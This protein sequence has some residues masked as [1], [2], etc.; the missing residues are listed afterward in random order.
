[1]QLQVTVRRIICKP[2]I[3][4]RVNISPYTAQGSSSPHILT[5]GMHFNHSLQTT[6]RYL[7]WNLPRNFVSNVLSTSSFMSATRLVNFIFFD[8]EDI[9]N[10]ESSLCYILQP[11]IFPSLLTSKY[12]FD[13]LISYTVTQFQSLQ[14]QVSYPQPSFNPLSWRTPIY[15]VYVKIRRRSQVADLNVKSGILL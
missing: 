1:M 6:S 13:T 7:E 2:K 4:C 10:Y 15:N 8:L 11:P 5:S 3:H 12:S 14:F 9:K